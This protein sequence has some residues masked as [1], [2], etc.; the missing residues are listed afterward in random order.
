VCFEKPGFESGELKFEVSHKLEDLIP[1]DQYE[2]I[3]AIP[4]IV[5]PNDKAEMNL[6]GLEHKAIAIQLFGDKAKDKQSSGGARAWWQNQPHWCGEL[7]R[8]QR[9]RK[10]QKM[11]PIIYF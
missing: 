3:T 7:Q 8:Q 6:I 1:K 5:L 10:S 11:K 2:S 9:F 4:K